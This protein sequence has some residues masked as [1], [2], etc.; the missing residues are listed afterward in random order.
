MRGRLVVQIMLANIFLA[1]FSTL[2]FSSALREVNVSYIEQISFGS[3]VVV[4]TRN[5]SLPLLHELEKVFQD[6][7]AVKIAILSDEEEKKKWESLVVVYP[8]REI[9]RTCL[10]S[11]QPPLKGKTYNG[12]LALKPLVQYINDECGIYR[13]PYGGLNPLGILRNQI[14]QN[15]FRLQQNYSRC[16]RVK[17]LTKAEFFWE[18]LSRSQ[19][20]VIEGG[21]K[22][23]TAMS[24]WTSEYLREMYFDEEVHIKLT[25]RGEFEGVESAFL[26]PGYTE[27][28]IPQAV[29]EKLLF[30]DLVV[31]RP[32]T[33]EIKFS[34][35]IDLINAGINKTGLSAYLEYSSIPYYMP[36]LEKDIEEPFPDL[37]DRQHLNLWLSDGNTLG[38][39]HFDPYDNLLCQVSCSMQFSFI[40]YS[41]YFFCISV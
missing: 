25:E 1:I 21:A 5:S 10:L 27:D 26:W 4:S 13:T 32:A 11:P 17:S 6:E 30:P 29:R 20:V 36:E 39:L 28:W 35:F 3:C 7:E 12:P 37:L 34:E 23:W 31:V 41:N 24:K 18:Y 15:I 19:P 22:D 2:Y 16:T 9:D 8:K 38:K 14:M 33:A 40:F